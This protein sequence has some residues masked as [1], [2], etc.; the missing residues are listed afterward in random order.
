V[1][2]D[3]ELNKLLTELNLAEQR[4]LELQM[5]YT[6]KNPVYQ[7]AKIVADE[8][9][10]RVAARV[11]ARRA[12]LV[13]LLTRDQSE[14]WFFQTRD[15][16]QGVLQIVDFTEEP[17]A[18]KIRYKL[19]GS[20]LNDSAEKREELSARLEA[21]EMISNQSE[22]DKALSVVATDAARAGEIDTVSAAIEQISASS[23]RDQASLDSVRLLA[24]RGLRKEA[25]QI[26][27]RI[28]SN[29]TRDLALAELAQ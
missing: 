20:A 18:V 25:I 2:P 27:Q 17:D 1:G 15:G 14:L 11:N 13:H 5:L 4:L 9:R 21:A 7:S 24:K 19:V 10:K 12:S 3:P 16:S 22:K 6:P 29:M 28:S 26:A 8:S 23:Y